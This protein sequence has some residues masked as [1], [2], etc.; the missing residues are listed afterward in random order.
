MVTLAHLRDPSRAFASSTSVRLFEI[1]LL[2][3]HRFSSTDCT[4][5]ARALPRARAHAL[6]FRRNT[7]AHDRQRAKGRPIIR[8]QSHV[9]AFARASIDTPGARSR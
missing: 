4:T 6:T 3:F 7:R 9:F 8:R 1:E 2:V 5:P